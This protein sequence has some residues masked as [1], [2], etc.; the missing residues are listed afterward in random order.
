ML[1]EIPWFYRND[2]SDIKPQRNIEEQTG[3]A[4][5]QE[6]LHASYCRYWQFPAITPALY[7]WPLNNRGREFTMG[8]ND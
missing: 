2:V 6:Y 3:K 1:V 7:S 5:S 8:H 4:C